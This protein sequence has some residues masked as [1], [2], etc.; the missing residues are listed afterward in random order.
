VPCYIVLG[1]HAVQTVYWLVQDC[2]LSPGVLL[3]VVTLVVATVAPTSSM[4]H[5]SVWMSRACTVVVALMLVHDIEMATSS[6]CKEG[7]RP[8]VIF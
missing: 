2:Y 3:L 4:T 1:I 8:G 7:R 5:H 6:S